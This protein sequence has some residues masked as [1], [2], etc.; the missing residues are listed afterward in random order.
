MVR[1]PPQATVTITVSP[2]SSVVFED[3]FETNQG[4][5]RNPSGAD[6]ATTGLWEVADPAQTSYNGVVQQVGTTTSGTRALVTDGRA[7]SSVGTYDIDNGVTSV[8]SPDIVL[9]AGVNLTLSFNYYMAH[10]FNSSSADYFRV[11]VVGSSGSQVVY[12]ELGDSV[13]DAGSWATYSGSLNQFAG[14]TIYLLVEAADASGGSL[15]EAGIDDLL[16]ETG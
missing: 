8:R 13:D 4:W 1:P 16:I 2:V 10:L 11:T 12:Q 7:G 14:Q 6:T 5:T 3:D 9:P 15:V